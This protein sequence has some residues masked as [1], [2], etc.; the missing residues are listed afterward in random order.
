VRPTR[1]GATRE[2][3]LDRARDAAVD[4][5]LAEAV[6]YGFIDG[7]KLAAI[8]APEPSVRVKNP[9]NENQAVMRTSL[10]P[11][12]LAC[13][14]RAARRGERDTRFFTVGSLFLPGA[15]AAGLPDER[16]A[17]AAVI[18]GERAAWLAK[19]QPVD[20]WDAKGIAEAMVERFARRPIEARAFADADRP[21]HLHPRGAAAI[22]VA[23]KAVGAFGLLH[24]D[25]RDAL[26]I[27][28]AGDVA[29]VE[30][31]LAAL[32]QLGRAPFTYLPIPRFPANER[33]LAI[34]VRNDVPAG[35]VEAAVRRAAGELAEEVRLFD[36]FTGGAVPADHAS[37]AFRVIYRR[38]DRTLTDA[39]VD[40][41]HAKVMSDVTTRF[42]ATLRA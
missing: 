33:D 39:E 11:G 32:E 18:T 4:V 29:L 41:Q 34:V 2:S 21:T 6:T 20:V 36:R 3:V 12:L 14:D 42:G 15:D 27:D 19:P 22:V 17:F 30:I 7:A 13:A 40:A 37:L 31:D 26:G 25:A 1:E 38:G 5:G 23:G 8:G 10:L 35:E 24:P 9:L 28:V 16:M